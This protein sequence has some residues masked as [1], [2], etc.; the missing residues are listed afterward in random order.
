MVAIGEVGLDF[1]RDHSPQAVQ[2]VVFE[3]FVRLALD[4]GKPLIVHCR[5]AYAALIEMLQGIQP[6][7]YRGVMHCYSADRETLLRLVDLGFH[8]SFAGPLTYKKNEALRDA[9]VACPPERLLL[10]TDA[11]FLPPQT[12]RGKRNEPAFMIE[13]ATLMADLHRLSLDALAYVTTNNAH[14]LFGI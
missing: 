1:Y 14:R 6:G 5:E 3:R 9:C 7:N 10:E 11:P 12:M 4:T 13:T 2:R 8:I